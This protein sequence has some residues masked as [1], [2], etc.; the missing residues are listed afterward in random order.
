RGEVVV[1]VGD[2][3]DRID[4]DLELDVL[5][6]VVRAKRCLFVLL[7]GTRGVRDIGLARAEALEAAACA[8]NP[9]GDVNVRIFS[10]ERLGRGL[11]ERADGRGAVHLDGAGERLGRL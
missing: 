2:D 1:L 11:N 9:D 4:R 5:D 7:D 10:L 6:A 8:G 3:G